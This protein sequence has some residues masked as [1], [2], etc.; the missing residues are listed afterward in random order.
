MLTFPVLDEIQ[1]LQSADDVGLSEHQHCAEILD[2]EISAMLVQGAQDDSA[3]VTAVTHLPEVG[4]RTL[5]GSVDTLT[6]TEFVACL[7]YTSDA[8]DE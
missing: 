1:R 6:P 5:G 8:A 7:L 3:P 2:A 4:Q